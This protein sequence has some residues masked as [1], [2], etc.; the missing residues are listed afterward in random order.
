MNIAD[1]LQGRLRYIKPQCLNEFEKYLRHQP[2][3]LFSTAASA[4]H[5]NLLATLHSLLHSTFAAFYQ[6]EV[7]HCPNG[8]PCWRCCCSSQLWCTDNHL[9]L[10]PGSQLSQ[11]C[12]MHLDCRLLDLGHSY[13]YCRPCCVHHLCLQ[14]SS[15]LPRG[16]QV[17]RC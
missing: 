1:T 6:H 7:Q 3:S 16:C 11:W 13:Y 14:P 17:H 9:C 8:S 2:S 4:S 5:I 12:S 15:Q 10:Q